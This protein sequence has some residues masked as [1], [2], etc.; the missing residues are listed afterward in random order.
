MHCN[1]LLGMHIKC[2]MMKAV[3]CLM[4]KAPVWVQ[5]SLVP[6]C[7]VLGKNTLRHLP[8][9]GGLGKHSKLQ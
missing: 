1:L 6:F 4:M 7:C 5:N 8:L 2:L 9:L 3:Y